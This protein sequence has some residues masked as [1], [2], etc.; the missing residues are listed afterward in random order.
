[1]AAGSW[2]TYDIVHARLG[3]GAYNL[4]ADTITMALF[5]AGNQETLTN[6]DLGDLTLEMATGGYTRQTLTTVTYADSS[7]VTDFDSD[8][9]V[10][11]A[12]GASIVARYAV[13]FD[14]THAANGLICFVK[15]SEDPEGTAV[16]VTVT[17]GNTLTI[18]QPAAGIFTVARG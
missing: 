4:S 16:D 1:M 11:S 9:V 17:D 2:T 10:F 14:D 7:G 5:S 13:L 12:S 8:D 6:D 15:L 3:N 18:Q